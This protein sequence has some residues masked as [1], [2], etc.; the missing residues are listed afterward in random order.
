MLLTEEWVCPEANIADWEIIIVVISNM[1]V[2]WLKE[3][4]GITSL[5]LFQDMII[6]DIIFILN[7][8]I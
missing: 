6:R 7:I 5:G 2:N 8:L 3:D 4:V 1:T